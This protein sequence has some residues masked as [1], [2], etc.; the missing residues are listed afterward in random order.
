MN[1]GEFRRERNPP[2]YVILQLRKDGYRW[3]GGRGYA[4][5]FGH[6]KH[7]WQRQLKD[8]AVYDKHSA[9]RA[10]DSIRGRV[11]IYSISKAKDINRSMRAIWNT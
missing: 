5:G 2:S 7:T 1:I 10:A 8:A 9:E 6:S 4:T 11:S 3:Y